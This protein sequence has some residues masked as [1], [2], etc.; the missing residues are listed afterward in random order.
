MCPEKQK[1]ETAHERFYQKNG[2]FNDGIHRLSICP[3]C[4]D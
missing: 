4:L 2:F 1:K 3:K